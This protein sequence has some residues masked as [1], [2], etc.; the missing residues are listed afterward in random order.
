MIALPLFPGAI[1][2][3]L[4]RT[5]RPARV[6]SQAA[7][8]L[9]VQVN[10][11]TTGSQGSPAVAMDAGG[12]FV[13]IWQ[14]YGQDGDS[15]GIFGQHFTSDGVI[16]GSEFQ[17]NTYTTGSQIESAVAASA[18]GDFVVAWQSSGQDGDGYGIFAQRFASDGAV[19]GSEF[20][21]NTYTTGDQQLP[22]A[23][24]NAYGDFIVAWSSDGQ[25]GDGD[26]IFAQRYSSSGSAQGGEFQVNTYTTSSQTDPAAA[27][28]ADGDLIVTWQSFGQ[29]GD[30][31]GIFAQAYDGAGSAQGTEFQVNSYTTASQGKAVT[32][33][34]G[35]GDFMITWSSDGQD[36][37]SGGIFAQRY[38]SSASAQGSE[39]R[40]N[41]YTTNAQDRP[42]VAMDANGDF[43]IAWQS[44]GQ[45]GS[46]EGLFVQRYNS[47]AAALGSEF[48]ANI[49]TTDGQARPAVATTA[50]GDFVV[51]WQ[52]YGQDGDH[53]GIFTRQFLEPLDSQ[54][55]TYIGD[56]QGR[57]AV[58]AHVDGGFA[59]AWSSY[60]Q[61][62]D[63]Y[64]IFAQ[65]F[66]SFGSAQGAE[67]QVNT[68]TTG[69]QTVPSVA[70]DADGGFVISWQSTAQDGDDS[71]IFA[72]RYDSLG[73]AQ[74]AEFQVNTYTSNNQRYPAVAMDASGNF[75]IAWH[76][77]GQDNASNGIFAQRYSSA[78]SAQGGEFQVNSHT[79]RS[80]I[81]PA[82][83][84][85]EDGDFVVAWES[86]KQDG[87]R[88]G[89]FA[90]R[91]NSAGSAQGDEFQVNTYTSGDQESVALAMDAEGQFVVAWESTGQD[92]DIYGI[93]AQRFDSSGSAQGS[94][95]QVNSYTTGK[96]TVPDVSMDAQGGFVVT[97]AGRDQDG[98]GEGIFAQRYSSLGA[99]WGSEFQ[100]NTYTTSRQTNPAVAL[101]ADGDLVVAWQSNGSDWSD[102]DGFSVQARL[103][104][105][106]VMR[107]YLPIMGRE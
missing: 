34:D 8:G 36:G 78:G 73:S 54:V 95:F 104:V 33:I 76:S 70:I 77:Y 66:D 22:A 30:Q 69:N 97:W 10:T 51:A 21:V 43:V 24:M 82:I 89:I 26:G 19:I 11:Y 39:F 13:A 65:R 60:G 103:F 74:G 18:S 56:K 23:A 48:Q 94:E 67:F 9:D 41:T 37:D 2:S 16:V 7:S 85:D 106:K 47:L 84:R 81:R 93:F 17:V 105:H 32:A 38:S 29:D 88:N 102:S 71:G 49:F 27:L 35:D 59:V 68:Y 63:K 86:D 107:V 28:D 62:G 75:V 40:V 99:T 53:D 80:Q 44:Y 87:D 92:G 42:A 72:Q 96:Q 6:V 79:T 83:A 15:D 101:D 55:N 14:S 57:P 64:G 91:F 46:A 100:V 61:D 3:S 50:E 1:R 45:D 12:D 4:G 31:Y 5:S 20:Q 98:D 58:A 25:D 90:Q 52:S